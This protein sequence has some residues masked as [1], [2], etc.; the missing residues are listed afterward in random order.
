[1]AVEIRG[2]L[3]GDEADWR[4]LWAAYVAFYRVAVSAEVTTATWTKIL[5]PTTP[6]LMGVAGRGGPVVGG[7]NILPPETTRVYGAG[8]MK[9]PG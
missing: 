2:A 4:R 8:C 6:R 7:C 5:D 1:M 3:P 9:R